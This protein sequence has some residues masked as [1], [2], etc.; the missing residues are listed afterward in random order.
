MSAIICLPVD[1]AANSL[2][3]PALLD[4]TVDGASVLYHTVSRLT[5]SDDYRVVL[6]FEDGPE[7]QA[8][9]ARAR[10][11]LSGL[12]FETHVSAAP[13]VPNREFL[14]RAR[15]WSISSWRGGIGATSYYD[16]AGSPAAM[17]E[18]AERFGA[19]AAGLM[20]PDSPF[21][22]PSLAGQLAAWHY[23]RIRKA[24]VTVTG[25]PPGLAPAFFNTEVLKSYAQYKLTVAASLAYKP[26]QPQRDMAATEAHF[27]ADIELRTAPWRLTVHS[28]RQLEMAR[29]LAEAGVSPRSASSIEVVRALGSCPAIAAGSAPAKVEIEPT[30][31]ID[32]APFYLRDFAASR[33]AADMDA[34]RLRAILETVS[35]REDVVVSLEG[36]GEPLCHPRIAELVRTAREAGVLGVHVGTHGR[37]LDERVFKAL[38]DARLDVLSVAIGAHTEDTYRAIYGVEGLEKARA[39]VEAAFK[40]RKAAEI[41]WPL[42]VA[43]ITKIRRA[44]GDIEPFFDHWYANCDWPVIR[45]YNDFAGQIED[46]ATIH[47]RTSS[48]VPCRKIFREMYV[49]AEGIAYPCRQDIRRTHPLGDAAAEGLS[50]LW[51]SEFMD[52]L[53]AAHVAGDWGFFPLCRGCKDWYYA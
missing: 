1:F 11:L 2:G 38:A 37:L 3:L 33:K 39:A 20:T 25:V 52:R 26:I 5:L 51:R 12:S 53:R 8:G 50:K 18:A 15:L 40:M 23:D 6:L 13:D 41:P 36:L 21:A 47:M 19:D 35:P 43:E 32:A 27:E 22:D 31:R 29:A 49:D 46:V 14:R 48:R 16:E 9:V 30:S 7:A 34:L 44:E 42:V 45:A 10:E 28:Q 24:R 17:L 4:A